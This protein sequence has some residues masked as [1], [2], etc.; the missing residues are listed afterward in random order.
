MSIIYACFSPDGKKIVTT[1]HD[2]LAKIWD[3]NS[4]KLQSDLAGHEGS[5]SHAIF[6]ATGS[7][8][9][10]TS[11]D[12]TV[13][14]WEVATGKVKLNLIGHR[15]RVTNAAISPKGTKLFT[16]S[17]DG[18]I[19]IWDLTNAGKLLASTSYKPA[20][21]EVQN[22]LFS[23]D[24]KSIN[25]IHTN[26]EVVSWL[27]PEGILDWLKTAK[28]DQLTDKDFEELGLDFMIEE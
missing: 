11:Y 1:S 21:Q 9:V 4:G 27:A 2:K 13:K 15:S 19:K 24:E 18:R 28:I 25:V 26:G 20:K 17:D 12:N 3:V 6:T 23:K 8:I 5:V 16:V 7:L 22:I 14:I 10:T